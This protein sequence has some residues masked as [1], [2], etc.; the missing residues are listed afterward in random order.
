MKR[1]STAREVLQQVFGYAEFRLQQEQIAETLIRGEDALVLMPTGGGKSLCYQI[2]ALVRHG[3]AVVVSP[4]IALMTDQIGA[5]EEKGVK[6]ACLSSANT[7]EEN[8]EVERRLREGTLDFLYITPERLVT[9]WTLSLLQRVKISLFAVDE[10]HCVVTWGKD[11]RPEYGLLSLIRERF[12]AVPRA[13]LTATADE[14][15]QKEIAEKLLVSP[16]IFIASFDRPNIRYRVDYGAKDARRRI[17]WFL[18]NRHRNESGIIYCLSRKQA[19]D[20]GQFLASEGVRS[21]V[22]HAGMEMEEREKNQE[23][24][25]KEQGV[26]MA[27]TVAFGMGID[28]PD[29]RFV[30]HLGLPKSIEAYFQ[31]TG[32]AGR[33]GKP[34]EA[35]L[36]WGWRDVMI[37]QRFIDASDGS[38]EFRRLSEEKLDSMVAYAETAGCRRQYLLSYFGEKAGEKCGNCDNCRRPPEMH[39]RTV[40]AQKFV[41]CLIRCC[42]ASGTEFGMSHVIDVLKGRMTPEVA[43]CGHDRLSTWGIGNELTDE[44]WRQVCRSLIARRIVVSDWERIG[45]LRPGRARALLRGETSLSIRE[46]DSESTQSRVKKLSPEDLPADRRELAEALRLVRKEISDRQN[47]PPYAVFTNVTLAEIAATRPKSYEGLF[48][49]SGLGER[50]I[51]KYGKDILDTVRKFAGN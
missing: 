9:D 42:R 3:T 21:L 17:L 38:E 16:K 6:A 43:R 24:F 32:R 48:R 11:F 7:Q 39:D 8:R 20:M 28:K 26:V 19:D 4:L 10:A 31:E 36:L 50:R 30:I 47:I 14:A 49:I 5:L 27:A 51:E 2:P 12:P 13:A 18:K 25:L 29:V 35:W 23:V 41:S 46:P 40:E 1:F 37:Q 44:E 22:Y 45:M 15:A 34:A 33:D